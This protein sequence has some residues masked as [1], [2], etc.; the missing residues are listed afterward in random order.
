MNNKKFLDLTR[1]AG[2]VVWG[3]EDWGPGPE[4]VDWS[5]DYDKELEA[6]CELIVRRCASKVRHIEMSGGGN[7]GDVILYDFDL[8]A[9][10]GSKLSA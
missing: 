5:C 1:E 4:Y 7:I 8:S 6:L 9:S 2:F 10:T 3:K